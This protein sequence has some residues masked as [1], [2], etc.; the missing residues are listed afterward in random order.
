VTPVRSP[1]ALTGD[2]WPWLN[3]DPADAA[4]PASPGT[5]AGWAGEP[6]SFTAADLAWDDGFCNYAARDI[7]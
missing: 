2:L 7:P 4:T 3:G 6:A 5:P 1:G